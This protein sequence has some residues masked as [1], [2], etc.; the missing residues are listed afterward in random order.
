[1]HRNVLLWTIGFVYY[2]LAGYTLYIFESGLL[3]TSLI[4]FGVPAYVL[5]RYSSAPSFVLSAVVM[6]GVGLSVLL[7]GIAHIYGI[8]YTI[9]IDELRLFGLIPIEV[10]VASIL[11]TLFLALLYELIFDDGEYSLSH[12]STR[13]V[14][15]GV[16]SFSAVLLIALHVY[17]VQGIFFAHSYI[18]IIGILI[19]STL[20]LL[21]VNRSLTIAFFD[22]LSAFTFV[23]RKS[24]V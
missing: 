11:Q 22:K 14:S 19:A 2:A 24:V 13:L 21:G 20:A 6:F 5:A 12:M 17:L 4:L 18:W 3:V 16:F 1:M 10:V 15:L 8:W 7:E 9:G 23:D